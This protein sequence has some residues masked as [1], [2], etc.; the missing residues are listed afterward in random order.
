M[1]AR[2]LSLGLVLAAASS[3][4]PTLKVRIKPSQPSTTMDVPVERYVAATVAAESSEFKSDEA[5]KAMAVSV[6][7]YAIHF[8]GRH[9]ADGYDLCGTTHCQRLDL[10]HV[11]PRIEAAVSATAGELL[12]YDGKPIFAS[13]SRDCG[14]TTE[15]AAA[16][17]GESAPYLRSH[18]DPYC[19]RRT[20]PWHWT[21][22]VTEISTALSRAGLRVP[23]VM[24]GLAISRQTESG[25]V[26]ELVLA[27]EETIRLAAGS[28][29]FAIGRA[30]GFN[31][32][33]SERWQATIS[34][35]RVAFTGRG[36]GHGVGLC[37]IG[38]NEMG[39]EGHPYRE[40][41]A[42]YFPG[43]VLGKLPPDR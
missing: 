5:L 25:R 11:T 24:T 3:A 39:V 7:T 30:A 35:G 23:L 20:S 29:R 4:Q 32:V 26:R 9:A 1:S 31:T 21:S 15:A 40:I 6:R 38:A 8:R 2:T 34:E 14:G 41:L 42:F 12:W 16:I 22:T 36:E 17:W 37:Q 18:P 33:R 19:V 10:A 28:F 13:Y 27:G 43:A